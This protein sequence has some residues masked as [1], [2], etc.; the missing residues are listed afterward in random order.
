MEMRAYGKSGDKLTIVGFGGIVVMNETPASASRLVGHAVQARG[1]NYFDVAPSYGNAEERLG[2]ALEPYRKSVFLACKTEKR[3]AADA[4]AAL[5]QSLKY[6]RT[7]HFDLYQLHAMTTLEEVDQVFA[8]GGAME[9]LVKAREQGLVR[10]LGFSAHSEE[11]ALALMDRFDFD[12]VLFPINWVSWYQGKFGPRVVEKA[13]AKGV[14]VLALKALAKRPWEEGEDRRWPKCWYS[15]VDS[16][17]EAA[18]GLRFTLSLPITA[19]AS[20]S[21][22]ELL[23]WACDAADTFAPMTDEEMAQVEQRSQSVKPIFPH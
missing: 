14:S 21:H 22:A 10:H 3:T 4:E 12:S 17:E 15:P 20:P 16:F 5:H 13:Q 18:M 19:A 23:W 9:T 11:A 2:P 7:D 6:L 8:P 1:I